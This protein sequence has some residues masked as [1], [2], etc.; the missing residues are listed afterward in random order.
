MDN[1]DNSKNQAGQQLADVGEQLALIKREMPLT[2]EV[3]RALAAQVGNKVFEQVRRGLRGEERCFF[4]IEG[5]HHIGEPW[6]TGL[7][8]VDQALLQYAFG[9]LRADVRLSVGVQP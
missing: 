6:D 1:L 4:A 5:D 2:Y 7:F 9:R 3:I 8:G